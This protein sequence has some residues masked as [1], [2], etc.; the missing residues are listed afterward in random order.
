[1]LDI[2]VKDILNFLQIE[3]KDLSEKELLTKIK[4]ISVNSKIIKEKIIF[5]SY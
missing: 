3:K 2:T 1:M 5:W 4:N